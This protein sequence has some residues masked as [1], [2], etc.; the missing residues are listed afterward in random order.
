VGEESIILSITTPEVRMAKKA[1]KT[2][3]KNNGI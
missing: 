1:L 2:P 3:N